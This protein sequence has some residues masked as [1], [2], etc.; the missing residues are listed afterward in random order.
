MKQLE[1][2]NPDFHVVGPTIDVFLSA[3]GPYKQR[4]EKILLRC[5]GVEKLDM[6]AEATYP[7]E[8]YLAAY[9][10][11]LNTFGREFLEPQQVPPC[12]LLRHRAHV[13]RFGRNCRHG[14]A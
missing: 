3:F 1:C 9:Q 8:Q 14:V 6:R 2:P 7:M 12:P 4:G 11:L 13:D 10:E 5:L